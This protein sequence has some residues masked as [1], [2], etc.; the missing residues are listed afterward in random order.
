M[1]EEYETVFDG[2]YES[3][4]DYPKGANDQI[5]AGLCYIFGWIVAL[6]CLLAIKPLSPYLRF[7]ACQALGLQV[8]YI[9]GYLVTVILMFVFIGFLL[10]PFLLGFSI[11]VLIV[12]IIILTGGDHRVP[13]LGDYVEENYV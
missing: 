10:L 12:G 13:M 4:L 3:Y 6:I 2:E 7:H 1:E 5:L 8:V 9:V 11:Y